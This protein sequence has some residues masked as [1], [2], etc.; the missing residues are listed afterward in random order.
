[1]AA[2]QIVAS[3]RNVKGKQFIRLDYVDIKMSKII[4]SD[5]WG[6]NVLGQYEAPVEVGAEI[7][8]MYRDNGFSVGADPALISWMQAQRAI[9]EREKTRIEKD[10]A[11][12][13][14]KLFPYQKE[15]SMVLSGRN[16]F[17]LSDEM[18]LGKTYQAIFAAGPLSPLV[19]ICPS[20]VKYNWEKEVKKVYPS[21]Q[22]FIGEGEQDEWCWPSAGQVVIIN[23]DILPPTNREKYGTDSDADLSIPIAH[24]G[25]NHG[26]I[27]IIDEAHMGKNRKSRRTER[28]KAVLAGA[29]E[30]NG[31]N[32]LLT[33]TPLL[34]RPLELWN[35][36][37]LAGISRA[38]FGSFQRFVKLFN[39]RRARFGYEWGLPKEEVFDIMKHTILR[40]VK[41]EVLKDLPPKRYQEIVIDPL[42][43]RPPVEGLDRMSEDT[44][45]SAPAI[46]K[47]RKVLAQDK[48]KELLALIEAY[49]SADEPI[50]VFSAHTYPIELLSRRD[51]WKGIWGDVSPQQRKLVIDRFQQGA[52]KGVALT[53]GAG[54][55]GITLTRAS[56]VVFIDRD[57]TPATNQQAEDRLHRI[58]QKNAVLVIDIKSSDPV[59]SRVWE[60]IMGKKELI[61]KSGLGNG[62]AT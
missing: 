27:V 7:L 8:R 35:V 6:K 9:V 33:A 4:R 54:G 58:G 28:M 52:L 60:V 38:T 46:A 40:R 61:E 53:I 21:R 31:R 34:N 24:P 17:L 39:G 10:E 18:G 56:T 47:R 22:V 30:V 2:R 42:E 55:V 26:T 3:L 44:L 32:W 62:A 43:D 48:V 50:V 15:G 41:A 25:A 51:G 13:G 37:E 45:K 57:W 23:P 19:I 1:M 20:V 11:N 12:C 5:P 36:L 59:E 14:V 16:A 49:E 29:R